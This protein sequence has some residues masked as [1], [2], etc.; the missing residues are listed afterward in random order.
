[1]GEPFNKV[2]APVPDDVVDLGDG[3][4]FDGGEAHGVGLPAVEQ[5]VVGWASCSGFWR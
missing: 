5:V 2:D 4:V 1:M 3:G